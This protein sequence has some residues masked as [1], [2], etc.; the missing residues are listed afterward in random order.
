MSLGR[1]VLVWIC[2]PS[3]SSHGEVRAWTV[4]VTKK[5][6][7]ELITAIQKVEVW[8]ETGDYDFTENGHIDMTSDQDIREKDSRDEMKRP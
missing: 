3:Q 4:K 2:P 5:W 7:A 6:S 1:A 8:M